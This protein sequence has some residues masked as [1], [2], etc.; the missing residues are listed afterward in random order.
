MKFLA[1]DTISNL[2]PLMYLQL[3][4]VGAY[5]VCIETE[6]DQDTL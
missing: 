3:E 6:V 5:N 2:E 1:L 4:K